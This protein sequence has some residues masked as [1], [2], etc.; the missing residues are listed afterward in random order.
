[1]GGQP[2]CAIAQNSGAICAGCDAG[3]WQW[4]GWK[5]RCW[6]GGVSKEL[7]R[8]RRMLGGDG[9]AWRGW[10]NYALDKAEW[11]R[12]KLSAVS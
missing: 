11:F 9:D 7:M 6:R 1:M 10:R 4:N 3:V 12:A 2:I 5:L 8:A